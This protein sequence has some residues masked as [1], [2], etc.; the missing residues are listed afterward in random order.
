M[1]E[2][3]STRDWLGNFGSGFSAGLAAFE[4]DLAEEGFVFELLEPG[5]VAIG[6][7][8]CAEGAV[9]H[10][11]AGLGEVVVVFGFIEGVIS[12]TAEVLGD[13]EE[14]IGEWLLDHGAVVVQPVGGLHGAGD[15]CR[16]GGRANR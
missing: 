5:E 7:A 2:A 8:F 14:L 1:T 4:L 13:G 15:Q 11:G 10:L 3:G 16:A 12:G 6:V 9:I